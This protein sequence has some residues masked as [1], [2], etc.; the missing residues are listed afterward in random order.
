ML[1]SFPGLRRALHQYRGSRLGSV[2]QAKLKQARGVAASISIFMFLAG[3][4]TCPCV[5]AGPDDL[6]AVRL[7]DAYRPYP[8][9]VLVAPFKLGGL[10]AHVVQ[11]GRY[12]VSARSGKTEI[13]NL[14][15]NEVVP[16]TGRE[17]QI[18]AAGGSPLVLMHERAG[19]RLYRGRIVLK[20]SAA[21]SL[22][23][24]NIVKPR[25]YVAAVV[26]S[27]TYP[28]WPAEALKAQAILSQTRLAR[29]RSG[30]ILADSTADESYLGCGGVREEV[31]DAVNSVWGMVLTYAGSLAEPYYH[32]TCAGGTSDGENIFQLK[33]QAPYLQAVACSFCRESNFWKS[34]RS[35]I[36]AVVFRKH[37]GSL[38]PAVVAKDNQ[39]RPLAISLGERLV[40]GFVFWQ[41]IGKDLGWDKVPGNR[42]DIKAVSS[43]IVIT[44]SGAG[45][46]VGMCQ[47]GAAGLA[48][49][50]RTH[51]EILAYYFPG[52]EVIAVP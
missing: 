1:S 8:T 25:E 27:E 2:G 22:D 30:E 11:E 7:C 31:V 34:K 42:F 51:K 38:M 14:R 43:T 48:G 50:G 52:T 29:M 24:V 21:G 37:F 49:L 16:V 39:G 13:R 28:G 36:P 26:S 35:V 17:V 20:S 4:F 32:S 23:I 41:Q 33:K 10:V 15:T 3:L 18:L 45:H 44:S 47:W 46:G 40:P 6:V 9:I 12:R 5:E 19:R